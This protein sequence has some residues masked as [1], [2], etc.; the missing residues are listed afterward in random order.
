MIRHEFHFLVLHNSLVLFTE[1]TDYTCTSLIHTQ[2]NLNIKLTKIIYN[3]SL[4]L[5]RFF[6]GETHFTTYQADPKLFLGG[7]FD[8]CSTAWKSSFEAELL[9]FDVWWK[10]WSASAKYVPVGQFL[11]PVL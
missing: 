8:H 6:F 10:R 7:S 3:S 11:R 9:K 4:L 2:V 5:D 1:I